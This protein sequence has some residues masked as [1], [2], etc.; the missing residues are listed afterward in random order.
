MSSVPWAWSGD[1]LL[2]LPLLAP[3]TGGCTW[4]PW[5]VGIVCLYYPHSSPS[6][7]L[8]MTGYR[9]EFLWFIS[10]QHIES[11]SGIEFG[12][13]EGCSCSLI[14]LMGPVVDKS[15]L[16]PFPELDWNCKMTLQKPLCPSC[17]IKHKLG[18]FAFL[19]VQLQSSNELLPIIITD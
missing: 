9:Y 4:L 10:C 16:E 15:S 6:H 5:V 13:T 2:P 8:A 3:F 11:L 12:T 14:S 1:I 7:Y 18:C 17:W 19:N